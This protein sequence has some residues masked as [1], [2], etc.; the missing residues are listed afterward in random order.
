MAP[1]HQPAERPKIKIERIWRNV[2]PRAH[3][4]N[5]VLCVEQ[6]SSKRFSL[7]VGNRTRFHT[8]NSLH[9]QQAPQKLN[10]SQNQPC[11]IT[12]YIGWI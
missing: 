7:K 9:L 6:G 10:Q 4:H 5:G 8:P 2:Q 11:K 1:L 12:L 3:S